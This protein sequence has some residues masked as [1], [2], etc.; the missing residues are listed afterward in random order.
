[1]KKFITLFMILSL[2]MLT[3]EALAK[4]LLSVNMKAETE[5]TVNNVTKKVAA[6]TD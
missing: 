1:M 3:M 4:P 6:D 5:V 2:L